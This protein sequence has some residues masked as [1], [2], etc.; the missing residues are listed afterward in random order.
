M[1]RYTTG[2]SVKQELKDYNLYTLLPATTLDQLFD[3]TSADTDYSGQSLLDYYTWSLLNDPARSEGAASTTPLPLEDGN[4]YSIVVINESS[5]AAFHKIPLSNNN[6]DLVVCGDGALKP[7][8]D[9]IAITP[10][11]G[12]SIESIKDGEVNFAQKISLDM[13]AMTDTE[14]GEQTGLDKP[15]VVL[16]NPT[17]ES[18]LYTVKIGVGGVLARLATATNKDSALGSKDV[19]PVY[20]QNGTVEFVDYG[21]IATNYS[22]GDGISIDSGKINVALNGATTSAADQSEKFTLYF[23]TNNQKKLTLN[24]PGIFDRSFNNLPSKGYF[25]V[26]SGDSSIVSVETLKTDLEAAGISSG[27]YNVMQTADSS[28]MY[29][30]GIKSDI[31]ASA[32]TVNSGDASLAVMPSVY[33]Y[34]GGLYQTSDERLKDFKEELDIDFD[35]LVA[36]HKRKFVWKND[37]TGKMN[38]GLSAQEVQ[39]IFPEVVSEDEKGIL[40]VSYE[41]LSVIALAAIDKLAERINNLEQRIGQLENR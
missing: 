19:V 25:R 13:S 27:V 6:S 18:S 30:T 32:S 17:V 15:A 14:L 21:A 26:A 37:G 34:A 1:A 4:D 9:F 38:I 11:N 22:A 41:R 23:N 8:S 35:E 39:A 33:A 12:I 29:L 5:T 31:D 2:N 28:K 36:I 20:K 24:V 10:G 40:S 7:M 3:S 16:Q